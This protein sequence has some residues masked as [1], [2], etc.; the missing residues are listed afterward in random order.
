MCIKYLCM[1]YLSLVKSFRQAIAFSLRKF[2]P[3]V[4]TNVKGSCPGIFSFLLL[5]SLNFELPNFT[6]PFSKKLFENDSGS[7]ASSLETTH[8]QVP[9]TTSTTLQRKSSVLNLQY[10]CKIKNSP[11]QPLLQKASLPRENQS[12]PPRLLTMIRLSSRHQH[13]R[14]LQLLTKFFLHR[15]SIFLCTRSA[16]KWR[17]VYP[18]EKSCVSVRASLRVIHIQVRMEVREWTYPPL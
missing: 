3:E 10:P 17:E 12:E 18:D 6:I 13:P 11:P 16:E 5:R 8:D 15:P 14:S 2:T 9:L 7:P 4:D 1:S